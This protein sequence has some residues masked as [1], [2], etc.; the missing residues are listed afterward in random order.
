MTREETI[1]IV[2]IITAAYPGSSR[3]ADAQ[4]VRAMVG[5][6]ANIFEADDAGLVALAVQEHIST[7]TWPPSVA[8][9]REI[10]ARISHPELI[11]PEEAWAVVN[12]FLNSHGEHNYGGLSELPEMIAETVKEIDYAQLYALY[13][14]YA[15]GHPERAGMARVTFLSA[16]R[17][18]YEAARREAMLPAGLRRQLSAEARMELTTGGKRDVQGE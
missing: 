8:E 6:W 1:K 10:M 3:F 13:V 5:V 14:S 15:R 2:G 16:Y 9:I 11:P 7:S 12:N 18:R 17:S 4:A